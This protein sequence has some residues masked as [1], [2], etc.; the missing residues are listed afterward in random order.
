MAAPGQAL[1]LTLRGLRLRADACARLRSCGRLR[2]TLVVTRNRR[3]TA[4]GG[5]IGKDAEEGHPLR[6][7]SSTTCSAKLRSKA[8]QFCFAY[9]F[10]EVRR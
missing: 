4:V 8:C 2:R 3:A 1:G 6:A 9:T 10:P 7:V 5:A